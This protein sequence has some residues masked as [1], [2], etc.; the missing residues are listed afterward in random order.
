MRFVLL[1][2]AAVG[3]AIVAGFLILLAIGCLV[4]DHI[5]PRIPALKKWVDTLPQWD[6]DED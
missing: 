2:D 4:S 5:L 1:G 3:L 6:D